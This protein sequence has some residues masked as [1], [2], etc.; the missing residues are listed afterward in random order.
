MVHSF[1]AIDYTRVFR[2]RSMFK[3]GDFKDLCISKTVRQEGISSY[4]YY[5]D[6]VGTEL[7]STIYRMAYAL[8]R[9]VS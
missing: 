4:S 8:S 2:S 7:T 5:I 6:H 3:R 9:Y 1:T